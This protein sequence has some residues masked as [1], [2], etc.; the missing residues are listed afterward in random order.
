MSALALAPVR[1]RYARLLLL[2]LFVV[3]LGAAPRLAEAGGDGLPRLVNL[4]PGTDLRIQ[5]NVDVNVVLVGMDGLVDPAALL[6]QPA[7]VPWNGVPQ[8]NGRGQTFMGQRFDFRYHVTVAPSWFEDALFGLLRQVA[9]P[10]API[11][12]FSGLPPLP[13]TP[14]Q[15]IYDFCNLDP[16]I[17]PGHGCSFDPLVPRVNRRS[18]TQN[19]LLDASFVEKV[20]SQNLPPLLGVDVTRP[21]IV[22]L[23]WWGRADYVDHI[24]LDPNE[25][26]P[27]TG[28]P[29][30]LFA[31][32]ELAGYG[33]TSH[34]DPETC[35]QGD[36]VFHRLWFY[37]MSAGP[38]LRTG[39]F[40][41]VADVPRFLANPLRG[42]APDYR[43]HHT[44]DYGTPSGTY[45]PLNTIVDDSA[46]LTGAVFV[47]GIA[48]AGPIYPPGL[49][50]PKQPHRL[51]L[52]VNRWSFD[53]QSFAGL[54]DVPHMLGKMNALP[55]E[56]GAEV[57]D[58]PQG[59]DSE[60]GR[61]WSC[62]LSSGYYT[63]QLGQSCYGNRN[64]G[65]AFNDVQ[66]YFNDH[67]FQFLT[68]APDYEVPIFQFNVPPSLAAYFAGIA[69]TNYGGLIG[70]TPT[71]FPNTRQS[72]VITSTT[73]LTNTTLGHGGLL[74]HETGHHLGFSH[75]FQGYVCITETC[76]VGEFVPLSGNPYTWFS[77]SGQ[78]VTGVMTYARVN[79][80][81]SRFELDNLQRWL[82]WQYL[83]LSN[84]IV[85]QLASSP[86]ADSVA[87]ALTDADAKAGAALAAYQQY[88]YA[89]AV[90]QARASYDTLAAAADAIHV[91][92]TPEAYQAIRR[93]P[94]DFNQVLRDYVSSTI[95]DHAGAMTGAI[96]AEGVHGLEGTTLLPPTTPLAGTLPHATGVKLLP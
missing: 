2:L 43:F 71:I 9:A 33:G 57:T 58:R 31:A 25:P 32:N 55:Y 39:G 74:E 85:S 78:Y 28:A 91:K 29:R 67:Q 17:D 83:D 50:P 12:I 52:D 44:A 11:P 77:Q 90:E 65:F 20:L 80:D 34:V 38:M 51:V 8:A 22:L 87:T 48:F 46:L 23:N 53:G 4:T 13:I 70:W 27:D 96:S 7:M 49:T 10:Q 88:E 64:G 72:F 37:D 94:A 59:L 36:C 79:N 89:A 75:P 45:R 56:F 86:Q 47:S 66:S 95:G 76:G 40:D 14:A 82:T 1:V 73:P 42:D 26:D 81:Y 69:I 19:Y 6:A 62:S 60:L 68:G 63:Y 92:L 30:G 24:Y 35:G 61:V 15:A 21:T 93:N 41:L 84:F 18:I 54:L 3:A 5:Q 16:A